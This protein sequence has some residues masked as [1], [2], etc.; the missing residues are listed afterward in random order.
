MHVGDKYQ[1]C[2]ILGATTLNGKQAL[3]V[4]TRTEKGMILVKHDEPSDKWEPVEK[5]DENLS[6]DK[7][8]DGYGLWKDKEVTKGHLWWKETRE[9]N[10]QVEPDEVKTFKEIENGTYYDSGG[11]VDLDHVLKYDNI[12]ITSAGNAAW[13]VTGAF[14]SLMCSATCVQE[15]YIRQI[16]TEG[17]LPPV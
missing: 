6:K 1:T 14:G 16:I 3:T 4:N 17:D 7:L 12:A 9:K 13:L 15:K 5:L 8:S 2:Q 10:N 11:R